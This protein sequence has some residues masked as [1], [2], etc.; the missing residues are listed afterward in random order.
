MN[1]KQPNELITWYRFDLIIKYL[2]GKSIIKNYNT[3]FFKD[4]YK[5]HLRLWNGFKEYNNPHKCTFEA[6]DEDFKRMIE[7][8]DKNG[9]DPTISLVPIENNKYILNGSHRVASC[10]VCN[11]PV[12]CCYGTNVIDGQKDCSWGGLFKNLG[13]PTVYSDITAI[14]YAKLKKSTYVVTLFPSTNG[15]YRPVLEI[16]SKYGGVFYYKPIELKKYGPLNLMRE[17]YVGE[18]WAGDHDTNYGGFS[19]KMNRC[20]TTNN[21]TYVFLVDFDSHENTIKAKK[22]IR[23]IFNLG[24]HSVHINDTHEQTVRLSKI[25]FNDNSIHHLNNSIPVKYEKFNTCIENF[26]KYIDKN[27]LDI[28]DYCVTSSSTLSIY[29]LRE[30]NDLDY[31]HLNPTEIKDDLNLIHSHNEYGKNLYELNYDEI[32]LNPNYHFYSRG[33]K[34]ASLNVVKELKEKRGEEK[35]LKDLELIKSVL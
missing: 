7:S 20:Y 25:F 21:L 10:L 19:D 15:N 17:L 29:G 2:Y 14:E 28:D 18:P 26:K 30:G 33:V 22:E 4:A 8:I 34:F 13:L 23:D 11:K 9:F 3:S 31:L 24:N 12:M 32:I 16:L 5:E 1:I 6:F 35:D 27:G